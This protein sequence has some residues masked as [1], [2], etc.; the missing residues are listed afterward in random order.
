M[1][2]SQELWPWSWLQYYGK[3]GFTCLAQC[4]WPQLLPLNTNFPLYTHK[5]SLPLTRNLADFPPL[6]MV[7]IN[8][9]TRTV[10][11]AFPHGTVIIKFVTSFSQHLL[12]LDSLLEVVRPWKSVDMCQTTKQHPKRQ[13][14]SIWQLL[15]QY[16]NE[17]RNLSL[18]FPLH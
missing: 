12:Q 11:I 17:H 9:V 5:I 7:P 3:C 16:S 2:T 6:F 4:H 1:K 18:C 8:T 15:V 13:W 14:S 10:F